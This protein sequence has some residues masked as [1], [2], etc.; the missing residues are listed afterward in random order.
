MKQSILFVI[1]L[2][3]LLFSCSGNEKEKQRLTDELKM[4]REENSY[5]KAEIVGLQKQVAELGTKVREER[6][7]LQKKF[8]EERNEMHRKVQE[9]REA[10]HKRSEEL[11]KKKSGTL[12]KEPG[13]PAIKKEPKETT[14]P[15]NG[16]ASG[17]N[18]KSQKKPATDE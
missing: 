11:A 5:L 1:C 3:M 9:E 8:E 6:E 16:R 15:K 14:A 18:G 13:A 10:L 12:K 7:G 2:S 4:V 17:S